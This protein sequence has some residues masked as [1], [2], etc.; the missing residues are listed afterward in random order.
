MR[1]LDEVLEAVWEDQQEH[2]R[3]QRLITTVGNM[4]LEVNTGL[5]NKGSPTISTL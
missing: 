3:Q 2:D 4:Y 5:P 1:P